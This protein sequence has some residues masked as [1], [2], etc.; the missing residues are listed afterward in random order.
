MDWIF[1]KKVFTGPGMIMHADYMEERR[2]AGAGRT[3]DGNE[4]ALR[5][6]KIDVAQDVK[7]FSFRERVKTFEVFECDH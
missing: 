6:F 2:F 4:I 7:E 3:H 1:F 5:D